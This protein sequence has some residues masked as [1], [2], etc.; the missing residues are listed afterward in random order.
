[1]DAMAAERDSGLECLVRVAR[2]HGVAADVAQ[3]RHEFAAQ[4]AAFGP[5]ELLRAARWLGLRARW[6]RS[7]WARLPGTPLPAIARYVDG[8]C[9]LLAGVR[10]DEVLVQA[11][12]GPAEV[13]SRARFTARWR[14]DLLLIARRA[15]SDG[16]SRRFDF[17]WFLP[18]ILRHRALL[19]EVLIASFVLQL[20][21]LVSPVFFQ[22]VVDKVL[23]HRGLTTLDVLCVGLLL[24]SSFEV[25]LGCLRAYVLNHTTNRIDVRL[26]ADLYRHLLRLPVAWFEARRVGDTV[27]RVRELE[28][29]RSF[30]TG[31]A[32]TLAIDAVFMLVFIAVLLLYSR[33]LTCV[34]LAS[35]PC[36]AVL[37][38]IVTPLL[39]RR[40]DVQF[41]RGAEAQAYLVETI[42][43]IETLKAA[44]VEPRQAR[45]WDELLTAATGASLRTLSLATLAAQLAALVQ[46]LTAVLLLWLGARMVIE[47]TLTVGELVAFNMLATRVSGP[48]LKLAELWQSFQQAGVSVRRLGDVLNALPEPA[49]QPGRVSLPA[50]V[51]AV[52]FDRVSFR[53]RPDRADAL[54]D[55]SFDIEPGQFVGIVGASG[56]GKSTIASLL[57]RLHVPSAGRVLVDGHDLSIVDPAWLRRQIG[58]VLQESR[59]FNRSVRENIALRE[60]ALPI[61]RVIEAARLAGAHQFIQALPEAYDTVV[62]E[63][64]A[65]L[66]GGQKQRIALARALIAEPRI[67]ILDEATSAL[68]YESEALIQANMR[69]IARGR[70]VIV[71][72]HRLS[73][74]RQADLILVIERGR[75][76][77]R[78]THRSLLA[79][80]GLYA[81]LHRYQAEGAVVT[82][83]G[84]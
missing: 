77:E 19:A 46:K 60:P 67:L 45:R 7:N 37:A 3:L 27:A 31:A 74:V 22:V 80:N 68:D 65:S 18:A 16:T 2:L 76:V 34:V 35:L 8:R 52:S 84:G 78:G 56:S 62:G 12:G 63:Y 44:A 81:R 15:V 75:L 13:L 66:S 79:R 73:A 43:C 47:Q 54:Q 38:A 41:E 72:A 6:C 5:R 42:A 29:I 40:L 23:V 26:G 32:L 49:Q 20:L 21:A 30:L 11:P 71:I 69:I 10:S 24:V 83:I 25:L 70:T 57:Q 64:G 39:R 28:H 1:M 14:G 53:Y 82:P 59:L 48:M 55:L 33:P 51:G 36:Y 4:G 17:G 50:L 58:V 61:E 9:V